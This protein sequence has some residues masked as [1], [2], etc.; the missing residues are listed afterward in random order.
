M[1]KFLEVLFVLLNVSLNFNY[2]KNKKSQ[3]SNM[4]SLLFSKFLTLNIEL[5]R[6][7]ILVVFLGKDDMIVLIQ[8]SFNGNNIDDPPYLMTDNTVKRI[9]DRL[10]RKFVWYINIVYSGKHNFQDCSR[11]RDAADMLR[12]LSK[13]ESWSTLK[14]VHLFALMDLQTASILQLLSFKEMTSQNNGSVFQIKF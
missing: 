12:S 11:N 8:I 10:I 4:L 3:S 9:N 5:W 6:L 14:Y 7:I 2:V 1:L 13:K